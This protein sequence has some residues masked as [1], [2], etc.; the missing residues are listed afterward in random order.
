MSTADTRRI[1]GLL[2]AGRL[3]PE[4]ANRLLASREQ[5]RRP[6]WWQMLADPFGHLPL[7][8]TLAVGALTVLA[9]LAVATGLGLRFDGALD[10]HVASG[11]VGWSLALLDQGGA[12]LTLTGLLWLAARIAGKPGRP[13]D[14]LAAVGVSRLALLL[15][16][17][18]F[19]S[20]MP[21]ELAV[22]GTPREAMSLVFDPWVIVAALAGIPFVGAFFVWLT[23]GFRTATG[24]R[25]GRLAAAL[26]GA[27]L[28]A[29]VLSKLV[30][31]AVGAAGI[32]G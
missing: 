8:V 25:G 27:L 13:I 31:W 10:V 21:P 20:L 29:E 22:A 12:L 1:L 5:P 9:S 30:L 17:L 15:S 16:G 28:A 19:A 32:F 18:V 24:L 7:G 26:L 4:E 11:P 23:L 6:P 2:A 3:S 14:L